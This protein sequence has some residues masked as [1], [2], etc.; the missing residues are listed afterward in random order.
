MNQG[1]QKAQ[2]EFPSVLMGLGVQNRINSDVQRDV[3]FLI[4][5]SCE[6][7]FVPPNELV[8]LRATLSTYSIFM[9]PVRGFPGSSDGKQS[10]CYVGDPG[11][12][13]GSGRSPGEG[14]DN[15]LQY[16]CL[17]NSMDRGA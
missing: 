2:V 7:M 4:P 17:E 11:S 14:N 10:A 6:V 5:Q 16:P 12:I 3:I 1:S 13:P 9:K 8:S 15:S